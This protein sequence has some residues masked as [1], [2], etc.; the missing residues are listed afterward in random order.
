MKKFK[1]VV[2]PINFLNNDYDGTNLNSMDFIVLDNNDELS[3]LDGVEINVEEFNY[4][5][6]AILAKHK[7]LINQNGSKSSFVQNSNCTIH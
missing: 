3:A 1:S 2:K 5:L 6:K 4:H 7:N